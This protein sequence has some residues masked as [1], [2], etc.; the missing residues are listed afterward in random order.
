M[1]TIQHKMKVQDLNFLKQKR[2]DEIRNKSLQMN[3]EVIFIVRS[4]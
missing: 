3:Q 4:F 1:N 2:A